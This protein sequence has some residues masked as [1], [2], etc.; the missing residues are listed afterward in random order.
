VHL[1]RLELTPAAK[2]DLK[3]LPQRIQKGIVM[4]HLPI[5]R[6]QPYRVGK[7]LVGALRKERSYHFGKRPEYRIIYFVEE[8]IITVTLMGS[9]EGIYKKAKKR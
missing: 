1:Y 9:R 6:E 5:I 3:G 2:R 8:D 7:P 4:E